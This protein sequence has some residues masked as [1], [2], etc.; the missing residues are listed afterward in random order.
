MD[1]RVFND[2]FVNKIIDKRKMI[3][4]ELFLL[5]SLLTLI[6]FFN[7]FYDYYNGAGEIKN[8]IMST[9][10]LTSDIEILKSN[11]IMKIEGKEYDYKIKNIESESYI[12]NGYIYKMVNVKINNYKELDNNYIDYQIIKKKDTIINYFINTM[13]GG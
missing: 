2:I 4:V 11:K 9:L 3:F 10:I 1:I 13:K 12:S 7:N 8:N 5:I 6:I